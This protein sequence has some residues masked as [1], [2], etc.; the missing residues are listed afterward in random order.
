MST[1]T[2]K[3]AYT[4]RAR[5]QNRSKTEINTEKANKIAAKTRRVIEKN[6][7]IKRRDLKDLVSATK[8][9]QAYDQVVP[10]VKRETKNKKTKKISKKEQKAIL[11]GA[12]TSWKETTLPCWS[13]CKDCRKWR[14]LPGQEAKA[15][16]GNF[17]CSMNLWDDKHNTCAHAEEECQIE[18]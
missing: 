6:L 13:L 5:K 9:L 18:A 17:R 1:T 10:A 7:K 11:H 3:T 14:K 16:V 15:I 2:T 12:F 4:K 8:K